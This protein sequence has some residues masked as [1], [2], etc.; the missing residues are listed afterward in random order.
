M[1]AMKVFRFLRRESSYDRVDAL[2]VAPT[3]VSEMERLL[4][5][6]I[7]F[8]LEKDLKSAEFMNLVR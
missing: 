6:Y 8:I 2:E 3:L 5:N 1:N 4:R 7:R